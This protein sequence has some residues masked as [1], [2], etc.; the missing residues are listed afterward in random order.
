VLWANIA[1]LDKDRISNNHAGYQVGLGYD[2]APNFAAEL[3]LSNGSFHINGAGAS[4]KLS[5][6]SLDV[7]YKFLPVTSTFRPFLLAGAGGMS[8]DIGRKSQ[9][10]EG[11]LAE[12]GGGVLVGLGSQSGSTRWQ[13]RTE[14]KYRRE[15]IQGIPDVP[16]NPGDVILGVG[17][18]LMFGAPTPPPPVARELPPPRR[19]R[20]LPRR[21]R[22]LR[23]MAT[24]TAMACR[25]R[26]T[27]VPIR[28]R[29]TWS[30]PTV[31]PSRTRSSSR[32]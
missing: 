8:D 13:F 1:F 15:F 17:F 28:R 12:A 5:A 30:T 9:N 21:P 26:S 32:A 11:W 10:D 2:F 24:M 29:A 25:I 19:R 23:W 14:A 4:E 3:S 7:L 18:Q 27:S 6:T 16:K 22:P 31:A 20:L